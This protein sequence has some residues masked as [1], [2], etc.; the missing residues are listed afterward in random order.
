MTTVDRTRCTARRHGTYSA[1]RTGCRCDDAREDWRLYYKRWRHNRN[2]PRLVD[3][4]GT[5]RRIQA[6]WAIGHTAEHIATHL[7][8]TTKRVYQIR[9]SRRVTLATATAVAHVYQQLANTPGPSYVNR[10]RTGRHIATPAYW[11][12]WG[13]IDDPD[14]HPTSVVDE[15]AIHL[16]LTGA[17]PITTLPPH[18]QLEAFTRLR[19]QGLSDGQIRYRLNLS[20]G[21]TTRLAREAD[22]H[23]TTPA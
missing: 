20:P 13:T 8:V 23:A 16:V 6:L 1:Y 18:E 17:R 11:E 4:T 12:T 10:G 14:P 9:T 3:A 21:T 22:Q 7:G 15:Y 19:T 5:C 2:P